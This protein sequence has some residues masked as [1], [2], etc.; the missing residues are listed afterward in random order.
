MKWPSRTSLRDRKSSIMDKITVYVEIDGVQ[1]AVEVTEGSKLDTVVPAGQLAVLN[2]KA[3]NRPLNEVELRA[4]DHVVCARK[5]GK[6][7]A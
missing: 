2:G 7:A 3:I 6:A 1:K 5:S 4:L